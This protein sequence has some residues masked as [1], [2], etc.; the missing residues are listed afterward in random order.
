M[1][2]VDYSTK[3]GL[4]YHLS[5]GS[6]GVYFNDSTVLGVDE[7]CVKYFYINNP[8]HNDKYDEYLDSD[9]PKDHNFN[10]KKV[11]LHKF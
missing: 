4:G 3:Y 7:K 1:S 2:Y 6:M 9:L 10:K 5:C 8:G 11:L